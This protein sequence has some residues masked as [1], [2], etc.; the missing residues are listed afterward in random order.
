VTPTPTATASVPTG[1]AGARSSGYHVRVLFGGKV[2]KSSNPSLGKMDMLPVETLLAYF[3]GL[4]GE[5]ASLIKAKCS[6]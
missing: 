4:V 6:S 1:T 2:L 3:D 5:G